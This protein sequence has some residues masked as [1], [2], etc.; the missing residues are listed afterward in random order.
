MAF[1]FSIP[2]GW[3]VVNTPTQVMLSSP[4]EKAALVLQAE[5][6]TE[7]LPGYTRKKAGQIQG[8]QFVG[9]D[10]LN[11][12]GLA[13]VHQIYRV[14]QQ[15]GGAISLRLS[16]IRKGELVYAFSAVAGSS[17]FP[18]FDSEFKRTAQSFAQL[19]DPAFLR[20][21]PRE[22]KLI[23]ANGRQTLQEIFSSAGVAKDLWPSVA[24]LN[25]MHLSARPPQGQLV[26]V[27]R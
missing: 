1:T 8:S 25:G 21:R 4:D 16:A 11:I 9:D 23:E 15:Q 24:I 12:P 3:K 18:R 20:R 10:Y 14:D 7:D 5:K 6:T 22:V 19:S 26:K 27:V 2:S 13:S 17:D